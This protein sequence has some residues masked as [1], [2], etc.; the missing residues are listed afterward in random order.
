MNKEN[1]QSLYQQLA[2]AGF[3]D[4]LNEKLK[5]TIG[6]GWKSFELSYGQMHPV[7]GS[8]PGNPQTH[9]VMVFALYFR[10]DAE[11]G[12]YCF[13]GYNAKLYTAG[14]TR[15]FSCWY[16]PSSMT[17]SQAYQRMKKDLGH[18]LA[19]KPSLTVPGKL[20][21]VRRKKAINYGKRKTR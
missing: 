11:P 2:A 10:Q 21:P 8:V 18:L 4:Q 17:I 15:T 13:K 7:T 9:D 14:D 19:S 3:G 20:P 6:I 1:L 5:K 16:D 12:T